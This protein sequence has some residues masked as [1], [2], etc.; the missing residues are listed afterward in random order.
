MG[1]FPLKSSR[2]RR[3][4]FRM[5]PRFVKE[6]VGERFQETVIWKMHF[7]LEWISFCATVC[8]LNFWCRF[9]GDHQ[10]IFNFKI[11]LYCAHIYSIIS[12]LAHSNTRFFC[13]F[14]RNRCR[15]LRPW[16]KWRTK[17]AWQM[18]ML[19]F[20]DR[21]TL[22]TFRFNGGVLHSLGSLQGWVVDV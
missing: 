11:M 17:S 12:N 2:N 22:T 14:P 3:Y 18:A 8:T 1:G 6:Y 19:C 21:C 13:R 15:M 7:F 9:L 4:H 10:R 5:T 20:D 16:R